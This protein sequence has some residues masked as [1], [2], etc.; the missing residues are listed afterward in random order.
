MP[1]IERSPLRA[2]AETPQQQ[3]ADPASQPPIFD[4]VEAAA[5]THVRMPSR[6]DT[7][8][9]TDG[10]RNVVVIDVDEGV[11][12][13]YAG[14]LNAKGLTKPDPLQTFKEE[15]HA[16]AHDQQYWFQGQAGAHGGSA[17]LGIGA[18]AAVLPFAIVAIKGGVETVQ[19]AVKQQR[20][21]VKERDATQARLAALESDV[22]AAGTA[23]PA[24]RLAPLDVETQALRRI[25]DAMTTNFQ[26][27]AIGASA[28]AAGGT[29]VVRAVPGIAVPV[30]SLAVAQPTSSV[31]GATVAATLPAAATVIGTA[32]TLVLG[33]LS[34]VFALALGGFALHSARRMH[35]RL[36][37]DQVRAQ[38]HLPSATN[39]GVG[40]TRPAYLSFIERK[41][42]AGD[43]FG[44][45][46]KRWGGLYLAGAGLFGL[47]TAASAVLGATALAG[48]AALLATPV[49]LA[50]IGAVGIVAGITML[51]GSW[52]FIGPRGKHVRQ[53]TYQAQ[54]SRFLSRRLDAF[55][56]ASCARTVDAGAASE[57]T[58]LRSNLY[59]FARERDAL[60]Q[61]LL[62]T[63]AN[64]M[65]KFRRWQLRSG[66]SAD[67]ALATT[68]SRERLK[69]VGAA[70]AGAGG[71]L[72]SILSGKGLT[73][74]RKAAREDRARHADSLSATHVAQWLSGSSGRPGH[75]IDSAEQQARDSQV[76][77]TLLG[78]LN[79]EQ[80]YL[81]QKL[82][83]CRNSAVLS[84][85]PTTQAA[86]DALKE[87][88]DELTEDEARL[89]TLNRFLSGEVSLDTL[90]REVLKQCTRPG[91]VDAL[92]DSALDERLADYLVE[93]MQQEYT[94]TRGVLFD[95]ERQSLQMQERILAA[96][97]AN[98]P[99]AVT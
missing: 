19:E 35:S 27:G 69:D 24:D 2:D 78:M 96:P 64:A 62:R 44:R 15:A 75:G 41:F 67:D 51:A 82:D 12:G 26:E 54:Q 43:R 4:A 87:V 23:A 53:Q 10:P 57:T 46:L 89:D 94:T 84:S 17:G 56:T 85:V 76:R 5:A 74:A 47:S 25:D 8:A 30:A 3:P 50:V 72:R 73:A 21:L 93:G 86:A 38:Q 29:A 63:A 32:G 81:E 60:R 42:A 48:A 14:I 6:P 52:Q 31:A 83:Q 98:T 13:L 18:S 40:G 95:M 16:L 28:L 1:K 20:A 9:A 11:V 66:E 77:Q 65:H 39:T 71:W 92:P 7:P 36:Q 55:H 37:A 91:D 70:F 58:A 61:G 33:P 99:S 79:V 59:A 90:K 49:G 80:R 68:K 45:R 22:S 88:H 97:G 34:A